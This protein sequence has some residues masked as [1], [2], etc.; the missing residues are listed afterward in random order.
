[1]SKILLILLLAWSMGDTIMVD[2]GQSKESQKYEKIIGNVFR[3]AFDAHTGQ[4]RK[5]DDTDYIYHP[6]AVARMC[7]GFDG[8]LEVVCAALLHDVLEDS[9]ISASKLMELLLSIPLM[10][11]T[12][13]MHI[14]FMVLELTDVY[15]N[16]AYPHLNR[17]ER[18]Y[19]ENKRLSR[20]SSGSKLIKK[21]DLLDNAQSIFLHD[22]KFYYG[23]FL[24]EMQA[25]IN[26]MS[27]N[28]EGDLL[29]VFDRAL[30]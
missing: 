3:I 6:V 16:E 30:E 2:L 13:A 27:G 11:T 21:C 26:S 4:K 18:K 8:S 23:A 24:Q 15:T 5:Y 10:A 9:D 20:I 17:A 12:T 19:L 22:K 7:A 1:M 29:N 28:L 25:C 14:H